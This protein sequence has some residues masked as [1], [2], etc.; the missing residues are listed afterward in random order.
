MSEAIWWLKQCDWLTDLPAETMG[1]LERVATVRQFP[2]K[3]LV[4]FPNEPAEHLLLLAR[5]RVR[6]KDVS[7]EGKEATL[8]FVDEGELFGELALVDD[9]PRHEFAEAVEAC[10][11]LAIPRD[12]FLK[13]VEQ[14]PRLALRL[15][16]LVGLRRQRIENRL[17]NVLFRSNR[18]RVILLL[19]ELVDSHGQEAAGLWEIRL[20]LSHQD[21]AS[22]IGITRESVTL[23]LG[24]LQLEGFIKVRRRQITVLDL[25]GLMDETQSSTKPLG[26]ARAHSAQS[27]GTASS[28]KAQPTLKA[29]GTP[30][31]T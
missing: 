31:A 14:L 26:S 2:R 11:I 8:A 15:T 17:R 18:D 10:T 29:P 25:P 27:N 12:E 22:L 30:P 1:E 13:A 19:I 16:K 9:R 24:Q 6:L 28:P 5:G 20:R 23:V 21:M 7:P 4:Y 3:A